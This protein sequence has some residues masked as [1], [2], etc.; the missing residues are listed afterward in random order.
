MNCVWN[1][2]WAS[3]SLN[4]LE[5]VEVRMKGSR[6]SGGSGGSGGSEGS[7]GRRKCKVLVTS[8]GPCV[9]QVQRLENVQER[10]A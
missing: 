3:A 9:G 7:E 4:V 1:F 10:G 8:K 6:G 2:Q 5:L